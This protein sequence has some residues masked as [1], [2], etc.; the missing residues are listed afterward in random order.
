MVPSSSRVVGVPAGS[1]SMVGV[2]AGSESMSLLVDRLAGAHGP[3]SAL[4]LEIARA[5]GFG[6]AD[7]PRWT[8]SID[9]IVESL[10]PRGSYWKAEYTGELNAVSIT[11]PAD[12][13]FSTGSAHTLP[14]ALCVASLHAR[15]ASASA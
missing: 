3:D 9:A 12:H 13:T 8:A 5:I 11:N 4:D 14:L 10:M 2:P 15:K 6:G 7:V 1:E